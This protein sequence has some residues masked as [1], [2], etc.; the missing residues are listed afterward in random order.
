MFLRGEDGKVE[1]SSL[2]RTKRSLTRE[3][4]LR[5][6][7]EIDELFRTGKRFSVE[8][9][10]LVCRRNGLDGN[11]LFVTF[12]RKF[13]SSVQRNRAKRV[14]RE[15]YRNRKSTLVPGWDLGFVLFTG[16]DAP[17]TQR[18]VAVLERAR[19]VQPEL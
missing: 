19:V 2:W 17:C 18:L 15:F 10:R 5:T 16:G 9:V 12:P 3:E 8:S 7:R 13:G 4:R 6:R 14:V 1:R 11:R